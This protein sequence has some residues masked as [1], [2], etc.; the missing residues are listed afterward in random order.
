MRIV[1]PKDSIL[2]M[3]LIFDNMTDEDIDI[4]NNVITMGRNVV[5]GKT[6]SKWD[7]V[8]KS[9]IYNTV[10]MDFESIDI[11]NVYDYIKGI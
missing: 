11:F 8:T 9:A 3:W 7:K 4:I 2:K 10:R 1:I 5:T 6:S